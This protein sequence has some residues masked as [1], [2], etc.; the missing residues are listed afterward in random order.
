[1]KIVV[2]AMGG[3]NA[4]A[5]IVLGAVA[6]S[7]EMKDIQLCLVGDE[8]AIFPL[9]KAT[10]QTSKIEIVHCSDAIRMDEHPGPALRSR[11]QASMVVAATMIKKG[12]AQAM[13][14]AG[15]TGALH[16]VSLL[17]IGRIKGVRRPALA[18]VFPT[19]VSPSLA[20][21]VG[22]NADGKT[23]YLIQFALMGSIYSQKVMG[24]ER[25]KVALL[26][27]GKEV[28]K[29][30]ANVVAAYEE[31]SR[32][33]IVN[34]VGNVEPMAFFEGEVDVAV[35]DGFV[36]NMM[37][38]T[39]ES[40][41]EWLMQ[42]IRLAARRTPA[43]KLGGHLLKPSLKGLM[44]DISHSEHGGAVLLGLKGLVIKCHGRA[45]ADTIANGI[46][47]AARGV[48]NQVV[49]IIEDS[50]SSQEVTDPESATA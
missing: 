2:D 10:K 47:V 8:K 3:D 44:K 45:N 27:I 7:R 32:L 9:L 28:G 43:S 14:C 38:K 17:E 50:L 4:P 15:N 34:F 1:M 11:R 46:K 48:R 49:S 12:E 40:V 39:S 35:C 26:N 31:L 20:L 23:E 30:S 6:A 41:A 42:R 21:D 37:L 13:V 16:Q 24:R 22:A 19:N 36:G 33:N 29:G 18:A 5:E 25:P